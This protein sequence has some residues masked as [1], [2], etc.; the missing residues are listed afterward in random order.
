MN[1]PTRIGRYEIVR[2]LGQSMTD[3]YLAID[4]A[5]NRK[6]ALKLIPCG[7]NAV[8][9]QVL[10]AE[11]RG[12]AIQKEL[13][14]L[15]PRM[16]EI[17]EFGEQDGFF[18][19]AMQY[20]EGKN[21]AE[22]L[23]AEE[24]MDAIRAATIALE[25]LEQLV[26][27]HT[28][29][30]AVVHGDIKPSNI[31]L[32]HHDTV[33]LLDFG[34]AKTL[35][36]DRVDTT[37]N[38]GSPGYCSPERLTRSAVDPQSDLWAVGA[39]L[40]EMLAGV[41]PYQAE[42]T[43]KL[44]S[45]IRSKRAPRALP[46]RCPRGLRAVVSKALAPNPAHRYGTAREFQADLQAFLEHKPTMAEMERRT[47]WSP[48]STM[49]AARAYLKRATQTMARAKA[50]VKGLDPA[51]ALGWFGLGM[52]LWI[53]GAWAFQSWHARRVAAAA[54]ASAPSKPAPAPP[55][56]DG[57]PMLYAAA[58]QRILDA[59]RQSSDPS[60]RDFDW[61][62]AEVCL[63][64]A[65]ELGGADDR[66]LGELA[67]SRGYA[68]LERIGGGHYSPTAAG[69]LRRYARDQFSL[70]VRKMPRSPDPHLAMA[71]VYV[72]SLPDVGKAMQEF[73]EAERLGAM[74]GQREF[75]QQADAYRLQE[76]KKAKVRRV[77]RWR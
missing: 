36:V 72:Y 65:A 20:V 51:S 75:R 32:G 42:S 59:Y 31:H 4:T 29:E 57:L 45:L 70:A 50:K 10:E 2:R 8:S 43:R 37:H 68:T 15:D 73:D 39:T 66:V 62:K 22:V 41:P 17:Y 3:V 56:D 74:L 11:R 46:P 6:V 18:F 60:L 47:R 1:A 48:N 76:A 63:E 30:Q 26:K 7:G 28:W 34:I 58:G 24:A 14:A 5:E 23:R 25:I 13:R 12:A 54:T 38:F 33:R 40:Y 16:V 27:F 21:L 19:V 69:Q 64:R 35:R 53:G 77:H 9:Q 55:A 61:H 44:E 49:E 67:L 52:A 71:R